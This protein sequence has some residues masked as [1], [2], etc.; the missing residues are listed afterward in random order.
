LDGISVA[1][2][3][4]HSGGDAMKSQQYVNI[5]ALLNAMVFCIHKRFDQI[6]IATMALPLASIA[7]NGAL[8][9]PKEAKQH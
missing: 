8:V 6:E 9:Q 7:S 4:L 2:A 5:M 3:P 1:Q